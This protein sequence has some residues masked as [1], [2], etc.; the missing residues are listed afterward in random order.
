MYSFYP[1]TALRQLSQ[2]S[3]NVEMRLEKRNI[4]N[5]YTNSDSNVYA[6]MTRIGIYLDSGSEEYNVKSQFTST[7]EGRIC[8]VFIIQYTFIAEVYL[9]PCICDILYNWKCLQG[10][11]IL[12]FAVCWDFSNISSSIFIM[13]QYRIYC[14]Q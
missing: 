8:I 13:Y 6:P 12:Q 9:H 2:K 4:I 14:V 11:S 5:D 7:L 10:S 3:A 1:H